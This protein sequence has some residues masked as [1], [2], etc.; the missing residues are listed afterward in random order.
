MPEHSTLTIFAAEHL[1]QKRSIPGNAERLAEEVW[2]VWTVPGTIRVSLRGV[3]GVSSAFCNRFLEVLVER[4]GGAALDRLEFEF[5]TPT[6]EVVFR[7][8]L[9]SART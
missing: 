5:D 2:S 3:R 4:G 8:S 7:R 9:E 1:D 6:Q